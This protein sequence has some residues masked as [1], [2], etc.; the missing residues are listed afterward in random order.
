MTLLPWAW[1][2]RA[3][4]LV[5]TGSV[6]RFYAL[7][8]G[9]WF[10]RPGRTPPGR[11]GYISMPLWSG[12]GSHATGAGQAVLPAATVSMPLWSGDGSHCRAGT[13]PPAG[14]AVSMPLWS[15]DGS[16]FPAGFTNYQQKEVS[17]PLWSGDG[18]HGPHC[19]RAGI[20]IRVSMPLWSGDGSH[21][22]RGNHVRENRLV[23]MPL[24]SGE[25]SHSLP[26]AMSPTLKRSFY[27]L[28]VGRGFA[29]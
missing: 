28:M 20:L 5:A 26:I 11:E 4:P 17:M 25:G 18:S 2:R 13:H 12:D 27:A 7:M 8:V 16:H 6:S 21:G 24:W 19:G 22:Q 15:G 14:R 1:H 29:R 3:A 23:S 10:A 9:R